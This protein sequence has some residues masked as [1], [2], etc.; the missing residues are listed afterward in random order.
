[1]ACKYSTSDVRLALR[2][3][4]VTYLAHVVCIVTFAPLAV[5]HKKIFA[6]RSGLMGGVEGYIVV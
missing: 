2:V 1:M 5:A 3:D 6:R 4:E